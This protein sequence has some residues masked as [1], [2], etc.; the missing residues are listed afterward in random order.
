[1]ITTLRQCSHSHRHINRMLSLCSDD[2]QL[3]YVAMGKQ[4][5]GKIK[6]VGKTI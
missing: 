3:R 1:M 6:E 2:A 5:E 4:S